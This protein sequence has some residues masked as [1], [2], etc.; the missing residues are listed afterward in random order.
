MGKRRRRK[1]EEKAGLPPQLQQVNLHAAGIDVGSE[2]HWVAVPQGRDPE[3]QDVRGFGAFTADLQTL[4]E[5][6]T[7]CGITTGNRVCNRNLCRWGIS[8][9]RSASWAS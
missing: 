2:E 8:A 9:S 7:R 6:L 1:A 5:W 3:E 4:A